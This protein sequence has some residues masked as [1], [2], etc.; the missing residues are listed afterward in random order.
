MQ[1]RPRALETLLSRSTRQR[2]AGNDLDSTLCALF[3][4]EG[5]PGGSPPVAP[6]TL[7]SDT[8]LAPDGYILRADPV[9]MHPDQAQLRL[10]DSHSFAVTQDEAGALAA[11][12]N[13]LYTDRGW[14][15]EAVCPQR[16]Y[17]ALPQAPSLGTVNPVH[18]AGRHVDPALPQGADAAA[19]HAIMN[20]VQMLLH[21]HPVNTAREA[22]GE[23]AINSLWF[24]GGGVLPAAVHGKA[25]RVVAD[26]PLARGLA[27][28]AGIPLR[29]LPVDAA[30][31][32]QEHDS[33]SPL[34]VLD[35]LESIVA[36]GDTSA[37]I[38]GLQQ[39]ERTWFVP[40]LEALR[41]GRISGL[42]IHACNRTAHVTGRWRQRCFWRPVRSLGSCC[43]HG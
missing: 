29:D 16:W 37:W 11:A 27:G 25:D 14:R 4:L 23:P 41:E 5:S 3:G 43:P 32:L 8:G 28:H 7:L 12:C 20:E 38:T 9:H 1:Q 33:D 24:W 26:H 42:E 10:F 31:F 2:T 19:W 17:L 36:Y 6:F 35:V 18:V 15:L 22:R 34:V 21:S 30:E 39:L 40:V 13:E